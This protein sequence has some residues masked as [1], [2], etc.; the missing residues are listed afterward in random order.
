MP[1]F[2]PIIRLINVN[3]PIK[4]PEIEIIASGAKDGA[5]VV[6]FILF[7]L[8]YL[9]I[10]LNLPIKDPEIEIIASRAKDGAIVVRI[11]LFFLNYLTFM[12]KHGFYIGDLLVRKCYRRK[13]LGRML[14]T[15]VARQ[16][17]RMGYK[18]F[19]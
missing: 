11:I 15:A 12:A 3:L 7:F 14:L 9:T 18:R 8:N 17:T 10:D 13:G 6:R 5:V 4:D 1:T 19:E 2:T 16:A